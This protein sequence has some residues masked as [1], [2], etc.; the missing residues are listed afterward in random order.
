MTIFQTKANI[1]RAPIM[2]TQYPKIL[3]YILKYTLRFNW[4]SFCTK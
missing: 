2:K 4:I 1:S 3:I